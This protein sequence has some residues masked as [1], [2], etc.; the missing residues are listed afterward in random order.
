MQNPIRGHWN[1]DPTI[2]VKIKVI[3]LK[4]TGDKLA[5][6]FPVWNML[7]AEYNDLR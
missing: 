3:H 5:H 6:V 7:A 1:L 4:I 2:G